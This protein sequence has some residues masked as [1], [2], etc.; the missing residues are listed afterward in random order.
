MYSVGAVAIPRVIVVTG[1]PGVGKT[2]CSRL[3]AGELS[4]RHIDL[5]ELVKEKDLTL[6]VDSKRD[7][8]IADIGR[9][10]TFLAQLLEGEHQDCIIWRS[11]YGRQLIGLAMIR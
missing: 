9:L 11:A 2:V 10:A 5:G 1:T 6:D 3:L 4:A 8:I 7:T